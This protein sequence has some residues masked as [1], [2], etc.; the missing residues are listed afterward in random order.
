MVTTLKATK[1]LGLAVPLG[2]RLDQKPQLLFVMRGVDENELIAGAGQDLTLTKAAPSAANRLDYAMSLPRVG[3]G[4]TRRLRS[5]GAHRFKTARQPKTG[6]AMTM[7]AGKKALAS[8]N[9]KSRVTRTK[10][11]RPRGASK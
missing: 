1:A 2:A 8:A 7:A 6:T 5:S 4:R 9:H 11:A 10:S 3:D